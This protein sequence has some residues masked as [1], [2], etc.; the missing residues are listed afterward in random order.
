MRLWSSNTTNFQAPN[1]PNRDR[2]YRIIQRASAPDHHPGN[3]LEGADRAGKSRQRN[4]P[5]DFSAGQIDLTLIR[6]KPTTL[7]QGAGEGY[8]WA[9]RLSTPLST[10]CNLISPVNPVFVPIDD[11]AD[12]IF[13]VFA[14]ENDAK[15]KAN[16][17]RGLDALYVRAI[18]HAKRVALVVAG[19]IDNE[20]RLSTRPLH[21]GRL[22]LSVIGW[23]RW[24]RRFPLMLATAISNACVTRLLQ[25]LLKAGARGMTEGRNW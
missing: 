5:Y 7:A 17:G 15:A 25:A 19:S 14:A 4:Q 9:K 11:D 16:R 18:G 2:R 21:S 10:S 3:A 8:Q 1:T 23:T 20:P 13:S 12:A 6:S 24:L 22:I